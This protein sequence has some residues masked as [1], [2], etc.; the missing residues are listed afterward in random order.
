MGMSAGEICERGGTK[1]EK[2]KEE[3]RFCVASHF[4]DW[5]TTTCLCLFL[6]LFFFRAC[7][8]FSVVDILFLLSAV[9]LL[10]NCGYHVY[11]AFAVYPARMFFV[12]SLCFR[13]ILVPPV[14]IQSRRSI[15][16]E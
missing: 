2:E 15:V 13:F 4:H 10:I 8:S 1:K 5:L 7:L 3:T 16:I 11:I 6:Y 14:L 12:S 9:L